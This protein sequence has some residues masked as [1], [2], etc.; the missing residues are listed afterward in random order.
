MIKKQVN[1]RLLHNLVL[2][3]KLRGALDIFIDN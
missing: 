2:E 3:M 1:I